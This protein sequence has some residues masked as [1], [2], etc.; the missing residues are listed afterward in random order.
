MTYQ[1][2]YR[3]WRPKNFA[4]IVGQQHVTRTLQNALNA[5]RISHA[6]LFCGTRGSGKTTTAKVLA[7][8]LNC[9]EAMEGQPCN[10]CHNCRAVNEGDSMDVIEIDAASNRGIDEIRELREKIN[11]SP[12]AARFRVYIIDEVHMLTNEAFNA[13]LK[14]LEEPPSHVI[15]VLATT[16]PHKVPVT[17]LS[18]CQRFDFRPISI[19]EMVGRMQEVAKGTNLDIEEDALYAMARAA[20]GSLRDALSI[21]DQASSA[22]EDKITVENIHGIL[23]TVDED[24]LD[25]MTQNLIDGN[26]AG[27]IKMIDDLVVAGKD[28]RIFAR[29]LGSHIR[30]R[31]VNDPAGD[32]ESN[33]R[34]LLFMAKLLVQYEQDMKWS[35]QP[36]LL[37]ELFVFEAVEG[38][39]DDSR[40]DLALRLARLEKKIDE[41]KYDR[42]SYPQSHPIQS[43]P[44]SPKPAPV[45]DKKEELKEKELPWGEVVSGLEAVY[46]SNPVQREDKDETGNK[47]G[48]K[49][50]NTVIEEEKT[51]VKGNSVADVPLERVRKMWP[52]ILEAVNKESK[53]TK[54]YLQSSWPA[55]ISGYMLTVGF[56]DDDIAKDMMEKESN[57]KIL[58]RVLGSFFK[59]EWKVRF[60]SGLS[61]PQDWE[62]ETQEMDFGGITEI[63]NAE[64]VEKIPPE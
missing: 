17:I 7:K 50:N 46:E 13:L 36:R 19:A 31:L 59:G 14:T 29:Q 11:F 55:N 2:L 61:R 44:V 26:S 53:A 32:A 35:S 52:Q 57:Q 1:A 37:L 40:E 47:N 5:G 63:F 39:G 42:D 9:V 25:T 4:E 49:G 64:E 45:E 15:F 12:A 6:Y 23:G 48:K 30:G 20:D 41:M 62:E 21:M 54:A 27:A 33:R 16:E 34:L 10:Q 56:E 18:R 58:K 51:P 8:A 24:V 22:G 38:G 28:L 60:D 43:A 3:K